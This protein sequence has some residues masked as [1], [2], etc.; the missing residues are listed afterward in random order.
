M[1]SYRVKNVQQGILFVERKLNHSK[2]RCV[3][4]IA[5]MTGDSS[6]V[7]TIS[8]WQNVKNTYQTDFA[9]MDRAVRL[10]ILV[11][12]G[13]L[14]VAAVDPDAF[15]DFVDASYSVVFQRAAHFPSVCT[16]PCVDFDEPAVEVAG[17]K[18]NAKLTFKFKQTEKCAYIDLA[19]CMCHMMRYCHLSIHV[20]SHLF[21]WR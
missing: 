17:R 3:T 19:L 10:A 7:T 1:N 4:K 15:V 8:N 12:F 21:E 6:N 2:N 9:S 20:M 14:V 13:Y 16:F 18:E 5:P 11:S